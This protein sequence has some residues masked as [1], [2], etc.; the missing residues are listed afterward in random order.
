[1]AYLNILVSRSPGDVVG[2]V[3]FEVHA[4]V[5]CWHGHFVGIAGRG[6]NMLQMWMIRERA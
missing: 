4:K 5:A 2:D 6:L 1:M 3:A